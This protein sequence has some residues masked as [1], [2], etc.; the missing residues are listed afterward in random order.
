MA[1]NFEGE[2]AVT[3]CVQASV[4]MLHFVLLQRPPI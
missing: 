3:R 1:L 2:A 4:G